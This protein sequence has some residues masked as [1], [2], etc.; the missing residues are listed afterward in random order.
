MFASEVVFTRVLFPLLIGLDMQSAL[1]GRCFAA[2]DRDASR[3]DSSSAT[4]ES[5]FPFP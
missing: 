2:F 1:L 4:L 3:E 5:S